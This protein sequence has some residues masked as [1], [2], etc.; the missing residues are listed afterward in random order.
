MI[1]LYIKLGRNTFR[2]AQI[3]PIVATLSDSPAQIRLLLAKLKA[4]SED[5]RAPLQERK[6]AWEKWHALNARLADRSQPSAGSTRFPEKQMENAS[7]GGRS[8]GGSEKTSDTWVSILKF[9]LFLALV[10]V[11]LRYLR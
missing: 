9:W 4:L 7:A 2:E 6:R 3:F 11:L 1:G 5:V 8:M 10:D